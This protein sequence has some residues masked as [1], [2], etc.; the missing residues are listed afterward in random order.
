MCTK[1]N[2]IIIIIINSYNNIIIIIINSLIIVDAGSCYTDGTDG[3]GSNL[4]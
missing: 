4:L 2:A 1:T 3:G